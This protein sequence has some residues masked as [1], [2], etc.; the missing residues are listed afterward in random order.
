MKKKGREA[1]EIEVEA[2][3]V[4]GEK[5]VFD[6]LDVEL[7][8]VCTNLDMMLFCNMLTLKGRRFK[9]KVGIC[10]GVQDS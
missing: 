8:A 3:F 1:Y 5:F 9:L 10:V 7:N 2:G 6:R 4:H